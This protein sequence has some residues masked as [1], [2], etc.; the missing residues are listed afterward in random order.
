MLRALLRNAI[1]LFA[2]F[3]STAISTQFALAQ[4]AQ[5][6]AACTGNDVVAFDQRISGCT[7]LI[8][9]RRI[10][11]GELARI[12]S[13]RAWAYSSIKRFD[14]AAADAD[15]A[16]R[17]DSG[18]ARY[19]YSRDSYLHSKSMSDHWTRYLK[20][21]QDGQDFANWSGPPLDLQRAAETQ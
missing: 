17:L 12:Y 3:G 1:L 9:S 19:A 14:R 7:A 18:N 5:D 2:V 4:S 8:E 15:E 11:G 21:I 20:E 10:Q 16:V 13:I 6:R